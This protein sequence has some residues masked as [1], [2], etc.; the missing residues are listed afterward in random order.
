MF[1]LGIPAAYPKSPP[2]PFLFQIPPP[3]V[4][5][6]HLAIGIQYEYVTLDYNTSSPPPT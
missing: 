5:A 2:P 6:L 1:F 4:P 3:L